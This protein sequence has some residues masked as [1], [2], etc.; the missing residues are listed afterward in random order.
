MTIQEYADRDEG[1]I[2]LT[3]DEVRDKLIDTLASVMTEGK[4]IVLEH[5][6]EEVA[7]IIPRREFERLS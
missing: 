1:F 7:A 2:R 3:T 6:G 5:S 4:R